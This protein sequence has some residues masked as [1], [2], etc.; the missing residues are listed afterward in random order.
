M[1]LDK[2]SSF[3][4]EYCRN[5]MIRQ[6]GSNVAYSVEAGFAAKAYLV[7]TVNWSASLIR[8]V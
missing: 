6:D 4:S 1:S 2:N 5:G 8:G 3:F 7:C